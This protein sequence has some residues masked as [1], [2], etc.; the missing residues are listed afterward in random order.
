MFLQNWF[1]NT[2]IL[3][4]CHQYIN[5]ILPNF[6]FSLNHIFCHISSICCVKLHAYKLSYSF[7]SKYANLQYS[8]KVILL[9][10]YMGKVCNISP[11]WSTHLNN[12]EEVFWL[13]NSFKKI[14]EVFWLVNTF[15]HMYRSILIGQRMVR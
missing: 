9:Y 4:S 2:M 5:T 8:N 3:V 1:R 7:E 12:F 15:K 10:L 11:D 6:V 14:E 13:V